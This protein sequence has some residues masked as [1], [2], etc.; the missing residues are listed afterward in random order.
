MSFKWYRWA[1]KQKNLSPPEK[2]VL[3]TIADYFNDEKGCAWPSQETL[4][5]DTAYNRS[6]ISRACRALQEKGLLSWEKEMRSSGHFSSNRYKLH[7][8]ALSH[9]AE[10]VEAEEAI[11]VLHEATPPC[12]TEQQKPL[13]EPLD[14]TL[15]NDRIIKK[16]RIISKRQK[17]LAEKYA[18]QLIKAHPNQYYELKLLRED[19]ETFLLSDQTD[20][21]WVALG[22]GLPNPKT[23]GFVKF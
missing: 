21:D 10:S 3:K 23:L 6:T 13:A 20:Q 4:A 18:I 7:R 8:V 12:G 5:E 19:C 16:S 1:N 17:A 22:N 15:N 11:T 9:A 14:L 2:A